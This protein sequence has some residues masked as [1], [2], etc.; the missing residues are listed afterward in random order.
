MRVVLI[1]RYPR[2]DTPGWKRRVAEELRDAGADVHVLYSKSHLVDQARAGLREEGFG[3]F[4]RY[5]SLRGGGDVAAQP[6]Q[7]L[8]D[9]AAEQGMG[10]HRFRKLGQPDTL[11]RLRE[12]APDL[13]ILVGADIVPAS[14]LAIPKIGTINPHYGMLPAY[15][16][17]NVTE[18]SV[19][20]GQPVGVTVHMVDPGI[21]TGDIILREEIPISPGETWETLRAKHQD[22]A[23]RLLPRAALALRDGTAERTPQHPHEGRQYYRMHPA[24]RHI[25]EAKLAGAPSTH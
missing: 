21:D 23:A 11:E 16:G 1:S 14:V 18:W 6:K 9:W 8:A 15:R 3:V 12:L 10:V 24:L 13:L 7:S 25:A 5:V 19:L 4:K 17:M 2:V 20:H 22:V